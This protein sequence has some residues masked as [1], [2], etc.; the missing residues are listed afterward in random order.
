MKSNSDVRPPILQDLGDGSYHY[1]YNITEVDVQPSVLSEDTPA[2]AEPRKAYV[3]DTVQIWGAPNFDKCVKAVLRDRRDETE[4]FNLINKYNA[5]VLGL[6][7]GVEGETGKVEYENYLTEVFA[8][9]A[10][11]RADMQAAGVTD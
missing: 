9:K 8:V 4:E 2:D 5:F 6:S 10:M 1:N 11:V 3:C 7:V